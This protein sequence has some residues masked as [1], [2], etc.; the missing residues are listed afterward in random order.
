M[1][2]LLRRGGQSARAATK[3][4]K[5]FFGFAPRALLECTPTVLALDEDGVQETQR[6]KMTNKMCTYRSLALFENPYT[7]MDDFIVLF[8]FRAN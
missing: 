1:H 7:S 6:K 2:L 4:G 5:Q 8:S 3:R